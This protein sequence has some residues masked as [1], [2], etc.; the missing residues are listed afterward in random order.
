[1]RGGFG[2]DG[3]LFTFDQI[4]EWRDGD[5]SGLDSED[6]ASPPEVVGHE[7]GGLGNGLKIVDHLAPVDFKPM[8]LGY[9]RYLV[10]V[11]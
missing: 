9:G 8:E 7:L 4:V 3:W 2:E 10:V 1:M 5:N 6:R 11:G